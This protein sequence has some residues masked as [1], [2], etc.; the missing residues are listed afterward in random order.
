MK[1][2]DTTDSKKE[3]DVNAVDPTAI[4][5]GE[6]DDVATFD[7]TSVSTGN[8][9]NNGATNEEESVAE[10]ELDE[11]YEDTLANWRNVFPYEAPYADQ[12]DAIIKSKQVVRDDGFA[13]TEAACG[14]GKT[15][16]ALSAGI[17]EVRDPNSK[18]E[19]VMCLTS[20]KQQLRAFEDDM[21]AI[22]E[23]LP[24]G[25]RPVTGLTLVGKSD[26]CSW[27]DADRIEP[28]NIYSRCDELRDP[29]RSKI[30][31]LDERKKV[32]ELQSMVKQ[33]HVSSEI[34]TPVSTDD[35]QAPFEDEPEPEDYCGFYAN[36]RL[37]KALDED[38]LSLNG[39][40]KPDDVMRQASNNGICPHAA[41]GE[42]MDEAEVVIA[43]YYHAFD[44]V[45]VEAFTKAL[46]DDKTML[47]CDEAHMVVPRVRDLLSDSV[48]RE[49]LQKSAQEIESH[50][51]NPP[52]R[53]VQSVIKTAFA[54][55]GIKPS[56]VKEFKE[57]VESAERWLV[58]QAVDALDNE[59]KNWQYNISDLDDVVEYPLRDPKTPQE[60]EFTDWIRT[61][62]YEDVAKRAALIGQTVADARRDA[63]EMISDYNVGETYSDTVGRL[64]ST[65]LANDH[66]QYFREVELKK[67]RRQWKGAEY[68]WNEHFTAHLT[69]KNCIP[70][71]KI[72]EKIDD[73]GGGILMS[74]TLAP[75]DVYREVVGLDKLEKEKSRP[76]KELVYGL[77]FPEENRE[78]FAA[79]TTK[80]T[81][82]NRSWPG[83]QDGYA[84]RREYVDLMLDIA[85]TTPGNVLICMPSYSEG[86]WAA[87]VL[88]GRWKGL[89]P[90][91]KQKARGIN[92]PILIDES[93]TNE[94]T[95]E[96]KETFFS[97]R[98]KIL[99]TSLRGTLTEGVDYAGD[100]LKACL[101]CGVPI[102]SIGGPYPKAIQTAYEN[103]FGNN[104][105]EYAF[106]VPAV[107]KTRQALGR[108]IRGSDDVGVRVMA[109]AR[110]TKTGG[111]GNVRQFFP[112]YEQSDFDVTTL[113]YLRPN[114]ERFWKEQ[115]E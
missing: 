83:S 71:D 68:D 43:N 52:N 106:T 91:Q 36:Y 96:L 23:N 13:T 34:S 90:R 28:Y 26:M 19:R 92:K 66:E 7:P 50:V 15:L 25:V 102:R 27:V 88:R 6:N 115:E 104:G 10:L 101:V 94:E 82:S 69:M 51:L 49:S 73:F 31:G 98:S 58:S 18:Y 9:S 3:D 110:Y 35:W 42:T 93:S 24:D 59:D 95:E 111:W 37:K 76:V 22:N 65:W 44:P 1:N 72:A 38:V 30:S 12:E 105:F 29:V 75:L 57:F 74:A 85:E 61:A 77:N 54:Q 11:E 39:M 107:R 97:G 45:T 16:I 79:N 53:G 80:F 2:N 47:V 60:D 5:N 103:A 33:K 64:I 70:S 100:R 46:I 17:S 67:R 56:Q 87:D 4:V 14:T 109:D 114:L 20:V 48:S 112:E 21:T 108:V 86:E 99:I 63:A 32:G 40:M 62:G 55:A 113:E 78:S 8:G 89:E 41:L 81:Y 84:T